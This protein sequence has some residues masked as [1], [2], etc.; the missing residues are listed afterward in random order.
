MSWTTPITW[1]TN[2]GITASLLNTHLRDNESFLYSPPRFRVYNSLAEAIPNAAFT[3]ATF[4]S[5]RFDTNGMHSTSVNTG[6]ATCQTAGAYLL[7]GGVEWAANATGVRA[8]ALRINGTTFIGTEAHMTRTDGGTAGSSTVTLYA[9]AATDYVELLVYQ[10]SGGSL[11]VN[12]ASNYSP[13]FWG[14]WQAN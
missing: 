1:A 2:D 10:S 6:R 3:A 14:I 7:G 5:E 9:L 11:N 8:A 12:A 4:D 13:E